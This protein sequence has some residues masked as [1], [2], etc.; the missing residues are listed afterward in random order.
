MPSR[1]QRA[2]IPTLVGVTECP[3]DEPFAL[4]RAHSP[5]TARPRGDWLAENTTPVWEIFPTTFGRPET[6]RPP[7]QGAV[8]HLLQNF[9]LDG[10]EPDLHGALAAVLLPK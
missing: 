8:H 10:T 1:R 5:D 3:L 9:Y 6:S 2:F 4:Q 7:H